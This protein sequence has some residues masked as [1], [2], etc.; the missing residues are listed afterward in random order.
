MKWILLL[1]GLLASAILV[2]AQQ[3]LP[4]TSPLPWIEG[5]S[6]A[7]APD[8]SAWTI[9]VVPPKTAPSKSQSAS[10]QPDQPKPRRVVE[11]KT[12][13]IRHITG[14]T[15]PNG[16]IPV[17]MWIQGPIQVILT[18][19]Q[20]RP[21][22]VTDRDPVNVFTRY[23]R[24]DFPGFQ[25]ISSRNYI[26]VAK[27]EEHVCLAFHGKVPL[28][29]RPEETGG[30]VEANAYV[31]KDTRLPVLLVMDGEESFYQFAQPPNQPLVLPAELT[32]LI[33]ARIK[34][35]KDLTRL[36]ARPY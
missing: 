4:A 29:T 2:K 20:E 10:N 24:S 5:W 13:S 18:P 21:W 34:Y 12:G 27:I 36:P 17:E 19:G 3:P 28:D 22:I 32:E 35:T 8:F 31:D 7:S 9:V 30:T 25:W 11:I 33:N 23:G 6:L 15:N 26:G 1:S 14:L 16:R